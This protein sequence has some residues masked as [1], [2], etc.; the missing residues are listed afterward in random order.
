MANYPWRDL[1]R[2][3]IQQRVE[4]QIVYT[5][6]EALGFV[7]LK[8][9]L[10]CLVNIALPDRLQRTLVRAEQDAAG[11]LGRALALQK[12][13]DV[14]GDEM[15]RLMPYIT[16]WELLNVMP[17][18]SHIQFLLTDLDVP[19][20]KPGAN[21]TAPPLFVMQLPLQASRVNGT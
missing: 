11:A 21:G 10:A 16:Q 1:N 15:P 8:L 19:G 7:G 18:H 3:T 13:L 6:D 2:E 5:L 17:D 9:V 14:F 12:Y 20:S 4:R